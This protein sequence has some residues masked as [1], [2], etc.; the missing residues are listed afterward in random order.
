MGAAELEP[1]GVFGEKQSKMGTRSALRADWH[2]GIPF[3]VFPA[4][5]WFVSGAVEA[6]MA[7]SWQTPQ[8]WAKDGI[9]ISG[10]SQIKTGAWTSMLSAKE[11]HDGRETDVVIKTFCVPQD[12]L[13]D[14][15]R[16]EVERAKFIAS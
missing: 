8:D 11:T 6:R 2:H 15:A 12:V 9:T 10:V 3:R 13:G 14:P 5:V 4:R 16:I 1:R 7:P